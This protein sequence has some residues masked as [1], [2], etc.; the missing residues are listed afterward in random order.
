M[1]K[2]FYV[3]REIIS[4]CGGGYIQDVTEIWDKGHTQESIELNLAETHSSG[5][6]EP[7]EAT[8]YSHAENPVE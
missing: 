4:P 8:F 6:M 1:L 5:A 7:E 2:S 3:L